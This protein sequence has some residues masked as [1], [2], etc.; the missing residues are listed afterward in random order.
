MILSIAFYKGGFYFINFL[1]T[2]LNYTTFAITLKYWLITSNSIHTLDY[3]SLSSSLKHITKKISPNKKPVLN[4]E[5]INNNENKFRRQ[6][7]SLHSPLYSIDWSHRKTRRMLDERVPRGPIQ[8]PT[9]SLLIRIG[10]RKPWGRGGGGVRLLEVV[11]TSPFYR[12][13]LFLIE[14]LSFFY[15]RLCQYSFLIFSSTWRPE[16]LQQVFGNTCFAGR[17]FIIEMG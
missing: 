6:L 15:K 1:K 3:L 17:L 8:I 4:S 7:F 16:L 13:P 14:R 9:G 11:V 5:Q 2:T 10:W 12:T